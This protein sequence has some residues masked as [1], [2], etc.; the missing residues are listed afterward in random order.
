MTK[1]AQKKRKQPYRTDTRVSS[2]TRTHVAYRLCISF[3][4]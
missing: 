2:I 3:I 1:F 4:G